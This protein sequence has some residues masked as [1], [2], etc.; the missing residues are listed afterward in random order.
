MRAATN[1]PDLL[2]ARAVAA[3]THVALVVDGGGSLTYR[4][5]DGRSDAAAWGL[6]AQG[7]RPGDRVALC[8]DN[9]D[10]D[11]Y[12][13][14]YLALHKVGAA[15]VPL[16]ARL[17]AA[18]VAR[19]TGHA[20]VTM[21]VCPP[22][23]VPPGYAGRVAHPRDLE[24]GRSH[25]PFPVA[26]APCGL[27]EIIYTSGTTG[28]PKGVACSHASLITHDLPPEGPRPVAFAHAFPIGTNAA[29]ECLRMLLRRTATAV[30]LPSFDPDRLCA[31]VAERRI[32]RLQL[33]PAMAQLVVE[34]G[35]A[36]RRDV[37]SLERI[38]LSSAPTPENL[39]ERLH[40]AFPSA[41][42]WNAY[43]LT[44]GGSARTL[45]HYDPGRPT[46]VGRPVGRSEV[47]VV[48]EAG[49]D[50]APGETGEVLLAR[51]GTPRREYFR[52]PAATAEAFAGDWLR[53][54]DLGYID[55]DG[56]LHLVD[57]KKDV[58]IRGGLN[59][60][61]VEVENAL[62]GHPAVAEAAVFGVPHPM[63]GED[64]AA[65][66]VARAPSDTREV[67]SFVRERLG[68]H[69]VPRRVVFLE[70]LPRNA[71]GKVLKRELRE[72]FTT[73]PVGMASTTP[74]DDFEVAVA[75]VWREVLGLPDVGVHDDFFE[76]GGHS[77]AAA[78]VAARLCDAFEA[79][80]PVTA[81]F[82]RPTV[83][84]LAAALRDAQAQPSPR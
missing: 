26:A 76:L 78:Q 59:I 1:V 68:E 54:G 81:V 55:E 77:L 19:V 3:P 58:I 83:A 72:Q 71:A 25:D 15:A 32:Q 44:E 51:R 38:T 6:A 28:S 30:M 39:W 41:S 79:D 75:N 84:E 33:V 80:L 14:T 12:A 23:A 60:S 70:R 20:D 5:W 10:W 65:A 73:S 11:E 35:A 9:A 56:Y 29:Q 82:E 50:R 49:A 8:F 42:L 43:A 63:L 34:S 40:V 37:S 64:V 67:Q 66:V 31:L 36:E 52:D 4:D 48:D 46:S 24:A 61:S 13:L 7:I 16:S 17:S 21:L 74:R 53:T 62:V 18:E 2:R 69:K 57:R 47:R 27:A 22:D 45:M